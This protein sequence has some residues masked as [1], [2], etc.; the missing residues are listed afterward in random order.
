MEDCHCP[1]AAVD[2]AN[3]K[4]DVHERSPG[5]KQLAIAMIAVSMVVPFASRFAR[6][7]SIEKGTIDR[8]TATHL[9][10]GIGDYHRKIT[11]NSPLAQRY[12]D[13][14]L[15]FLYGFNRE[16]ARRSFQA[17]VEIDPGCAMAKWGIAAAFGPDINNTD[18]GESA[19]LAA[20]QA[21]A[22][23]RDLVD[24]SNVVERAMV[25]AMA[26]RYADPDVAD[27]WP[28]EIGRAHV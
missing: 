1:L 24:P 8:S 12:F 20:N 23:S 28:F 7:A 14:G 5:A 26:S 4:R 10:G 13:Q 19:V 15:A 22:A 9:F 27:R 17:A 11:T 2:D 16:E 6:N 21:I 3:E 18:V 25:E